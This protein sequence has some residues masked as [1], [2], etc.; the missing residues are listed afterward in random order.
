MSDISLAQTAAPAARARVLAG[1]DQP[2]VADTIR[3]LD[4]P[5]GRWVPA[6]GALFEV[7]PGIHWFRMPLPFG[8]DHINLWALDAGEGKNGGWA[9][10]DTGVRVR[11]QNSWPYPLWSSIPYSVTPGTVSRLNSWRLA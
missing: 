8:L 9:I 1:P 2:R 5:F 10:V 4:Y 7:A 11:F 6:G 3:G